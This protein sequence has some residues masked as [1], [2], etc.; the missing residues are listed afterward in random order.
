[1]LKDLLNYIRNDSS[2]IS[3][4]NEALWK[5]VRLSVAIFLNYPISNNIGSA[6]SNISVHEDNK[7]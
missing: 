6:C 5:Q 7:L 2:S 3:S 1:M 4:V